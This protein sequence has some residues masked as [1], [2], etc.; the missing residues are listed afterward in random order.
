VR[1]G[2]HRTLR[3]RLRSDL[4]ICGML[5]QQLAVLKQRLTECVK[6]R[7]D[8]RPLKTVP[9]MVENLRR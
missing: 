1:S 7:T 9:G 3:S 5:P 2:R 6:L 4:A 8:Y